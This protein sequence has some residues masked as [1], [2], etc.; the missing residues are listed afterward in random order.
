[1]SNEQNNNLSVVVTEKKKMSKGVKILLIILAIL[2]FLGICALSIILLTAKG[3][4]NVAKDF[5]EQQQE[6]E[7]KTEEKFNNPKSLGEK[8]NVKNVE[9]TVLEA[10]NLGSTIPS[11]YSYG[12]DCIA[13]S[14][15][16]VK[17]KVSI[18]N[19]SSEMVSV[20]D[21]YLYDDK[22]REF[23][24]SSDIFGCEDSAN[25]LILENINPGIEKTF[26]NIYEVPTD[27]QNLRVKVGDTELFSD[28]Y[29]YVSLGF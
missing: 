2:V 14:G 3:I 10:T 13:N 11:S 23:I 12:D 15:T 26:T 24:T 1:M 9:W 25:L 19:N 17:I 22:N 29:E 28:E 8:V 18:K 20:S 21:L 5:N 7:A 6:E 27:S 4:S 16:F